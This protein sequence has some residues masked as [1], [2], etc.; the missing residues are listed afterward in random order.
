MSIE[1]LDIDMGRFG[2]FD[3]L[4]LLDLIEGT[5]S[6]DRA[7]RLVES[8]REKDPQLLHKLVRMQADRVEMSSHKTP[9]PPKNLLSKVQ[10]RTSS[11]EILAPD[12]PEAIEPTVMMER[13]L[14]NLGRNRRRRQ[15]APMIAAMAA[16]LAGVGVTTVALIV[17][18][19]VTEPDGLKTVPPVLALDSVQDDLRSPG[20]PVVEENPTPVL[21]SASTINQSLA[22]TPVDSLSSPTLGTPVVAE[23]GLVLQGVDPQALGIQLSA[24]LSSR[25]MVLVENIPFEEIYENSRSSAE[26]GS[27][28][29][30]RQMDRFQ[31]GAGV[32]QPPP[33]VG[34]EDGAPS[35]AT[36]SELAERGFR[37]AIV[38]EPGQV[39]DV[40][41]RIEQL[42]ETIEL[43]PMGMSG[44]SR[45]SGD[46]RDVW[47]SREAAIAEWA[48]ADRLVIP[49]S[50]SGQTQ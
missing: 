13:S 50:C 23:N 32:L 39:D 41:A 27:L 33:M 1:E 44:N 16:C 11:V 20:T 15:R 17:L 42:A 30:R 10:L 14:K 8:V 5:M 49:I 22:R 34:F 31:T 12:F 36:R 24:I 47:N 25:D 4:D 9:P 35:N 40:I 29:N 3:Q 37:W 45:Q 21:T 26:D 46:V 7:K 38:L 6:S 48:N 18:N 28:R 43:V 19:I 2:D